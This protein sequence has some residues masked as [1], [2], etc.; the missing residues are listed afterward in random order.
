MLA[1]FAAYLIARLMFV[2]PSVLEDADTYLHVAIG[3]WI[4]QYGEIPLTDPFSFP[5]AGKDWVPHEWLAGLMMSYVYTYGGWYGL[6]V[7][8]LASLALTLAIQARFLWRHLPI[9][10]VFAML[11]IASDGLESHLLVR[12][13]VFVW[14]LM[15]LWASI[16]LGRSE[17]GSKAPFW[18]LP[19]LMLWANL[20]GSF[21]LAIGLVLPLA[22]E[23]L[24]NAEPDRRFRLL[25]NWGTFFILSVVA[26]LATPFGV[27][28]LVFTKK[29]V[30]I[31]SLATIGEWKPLNVSE[32]P[33][34]LLWLGAFLMMGLRGFLK[35]PW[36]RLL[37]IL[38]LGY[39]MMMHARFYSVFAILA[40]LL[41][42]Q[43]L[44]LSRDRWALVNQSNSAAEVSP[45][46]RSRKPSLVAVLFVIPVIAAS[47]WIFQK[48]LEPSKKNTPAEALAYIQNSGITGHGLNSYNYGG[49]LIWRGV[50]VFM[51]GRVDLRGD[52]GMKAYDDAVT[53][54]ASV[55]LTKL[56]E[57]HEISW[58]IFPKKY[59]GAMHMDR[60]DGW[61]RLYEDDQAVVHVRKK[62]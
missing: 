59:I 36:I 39:Q 13:H 17:S 38:G 28:G 14:P 23:A 54:V 21:L 12:P 20:H 29:L 15:A 47:I 32:F 4:R 1:A 16:L 6:C 37:L 52:A 46:Y 53:K 31:E 18:L 11:V 25:L 55:G 2:G 33:I 34:T 8:T 41:V 58:T 24:A 50:P 56:L 10:Y 35:L 27:D 7:L 22:A 60:E 9:A 30:A 57:E 26:C 45:G 51:D 44:A 49:Y 43:P 40:P 3:D 5:M 61:V 62:N 42:A 48:D 19:V